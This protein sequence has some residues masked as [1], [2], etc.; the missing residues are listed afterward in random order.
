MRLLF[1][2]ATGGSMHRFVGEDVSFENFGT[3]LAVSSET[4]ILKIAK[5]PYINNYI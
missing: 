4:S 1:I 3:H 2:S 5:L